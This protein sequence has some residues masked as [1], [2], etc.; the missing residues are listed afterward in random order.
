MNG[1]YQGEFSVNGQRPDSN[2]FIGGWSRVSSRKRRKRNLLAQG[3]AG[4]LPLST[5]SEGGRN[6]VSLDALEEFRVQTLIFAPEYGR[7]Q[8]LKSPSRQIRDKRIPRHCF[9]ISPNDKL[10]ANH[11]SANA[12]G[13]ARP[14]LRQIDFGGGGRPDPKDKLFFFGSYED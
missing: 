6:L 10:N 4:Q 9:R 14:E 12:N 11:W 2:Y 5:P 13:L 8:A 3:G 7:T 1:F